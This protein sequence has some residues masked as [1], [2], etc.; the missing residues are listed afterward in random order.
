[1][2]PSVLL[3]AITPPP[4]PVDTGCRLAL[5]CVGA[6]C[7]GQTALLC[8]QPL[9]PIGAQLCSNA[10]SKRNLCVLAFCYPVCNTRAHTL[11]LM[12]RTFSAYF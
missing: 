2:H 10:G 1:M 4:P 6:L 8:T 3:L 7:V 5:R 11:P 12:S 9:L